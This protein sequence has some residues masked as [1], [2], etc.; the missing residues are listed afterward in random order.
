MDVTADKTTIK[1]EIDHT[2]EIGIH[3][4]E[5]EEILTEILDQTIG[6]D[7]GIV[8]DGKD[9]DEVIGVTIPDNNT[10]GTTIGMI[11]DKM[12]IRQL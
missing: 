6:V 2:A 9:T 12:W 7:L 5:A 1:S 3:L 4:I 11:I 10:E 8:K